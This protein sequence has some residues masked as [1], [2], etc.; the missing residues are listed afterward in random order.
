MIETAAGV[1]NA[2]AIAATPGLD[3]VFIGTGDLA[4]SLGGFP[5]VDARHV[6]ACRA[7]QEACRA[8]DVPCGTFTTSPEEAARRRHEGYALVVVANDTGLVSAGFAAAWTAFTASQAKE[9]Q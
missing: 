5:A 3:F 8:A 2:A 9:P 4:L 6:D 7:V 1:A